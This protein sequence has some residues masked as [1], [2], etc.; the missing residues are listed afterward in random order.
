MTLADGR[1]VQLGG[2]VIGHKHTAY[3][4]LLGELGLAVEPS[5]M[6]DPGEMSWGLNEGVFVGDDVPWLSA[7]ERAD[8]ERLD[9]M[10]AALAAEINPDDPWSH[11]DAARLDSL[12]LGAWLRLNG[13]LPA[14]RRRHV[15]ASL[16]LSCDGPDRSSLLADLRKHATLAGHGFYDLAAWEGLRCAAGVG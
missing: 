8:A 14:V 2:E 9:A 3:L 11:P 7:Q 4:E 12:S 16:S 15:L 1:T 13:A 10:F 5:Y 6:A